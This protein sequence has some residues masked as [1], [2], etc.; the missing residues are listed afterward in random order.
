MGSNNK[1][2]NPEDILSEQQNTTV[3][4]GILVRKGSIAAFLKNL[5][6]LD[7]PSITSEQKSAVISVIKELMPAV[8]AAGLAKHVVFKNPLIQSLVEEF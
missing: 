3:L 4:N 8:I 5:D 6:L 7:N 1:P 2:I